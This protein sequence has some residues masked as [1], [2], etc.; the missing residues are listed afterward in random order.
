[1][2]ATGAA[3]DLEHSRT[4]AAIQPW[5]AEAGVRTLLDSPGTEA[6]AEKIYGPCTRSLGGGSTLSLLREQS[7]KRGAATFLG[8][9]RKDRHDCPKALD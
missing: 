6:H 1:M 5:A 7:Q 2:A 8:D 4:R 3:T 9:L